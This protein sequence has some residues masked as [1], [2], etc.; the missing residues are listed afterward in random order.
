MLHFH[1]NL[2]YMCTFCKSP[3]LLQRVQLCGRIVP[4]IEKVLSELWTTLQVCLPRLTHYYRPLYYRPV[5]SRSVRFFCFVCL[6]PFHCMS[7]SFSILEAYFFFS[8]FLLLSRPFSILKI[9]TLVSVSRGTNS[10]WDSGW[11]WSLFFSTFET[12]LYTTDK[13]SSISIS[14]YKFR[15]RFW[16][17]LKSYRGIWVSQFG[18]CRGCS[19]F[20]EFFHSGLSRYSLTEEITLKKNWISRLPSFH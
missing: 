4:L 20:N 15:L 10:N 7:F 13:D 17:N 3:F 2:S 16:F 6:R 9:K 18:V 5:Y 12:F 11:I 1:W 19:I 8:L 14:W